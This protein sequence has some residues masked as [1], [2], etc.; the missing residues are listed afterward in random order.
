RRDD[1]RGDAMIFGVAVFALGILLA[2]LFPGRVMAAVTYVLAGSGAVL[3]VSH[4]G[5]LR[6]RRFPVRILGRVTVATRMVL[7][8]VMPLAALAGG[9]LAS[10]AGSATLFIVAGSVGLAA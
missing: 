5:S 10:A 3:A 1:T 9:V 8:G 2:G 7:Y 6:Q 4:W